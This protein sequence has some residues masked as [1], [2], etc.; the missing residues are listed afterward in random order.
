MKSIRDC[1]RQNG[2]R[3]SEVNQT[4]RLNKVSSVI[5]EEQDGTEQGEERKQY[6]EQRGL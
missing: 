5:M 3:R 4:G 2:R 6:E 1:G